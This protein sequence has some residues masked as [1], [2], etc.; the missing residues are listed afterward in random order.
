[1]TGVLRRLAP[2]LGAIL[3]F[4]GCGLPKAPTVPSDDPE[5]S[6][7]QRVPEPA[8]VQ[9]DPPQALRLMPGDRVT[10]QAFSVETTEYGAIQVDGAGRLHVPLSGDVPVGGLTLEEA[11]ARVQEAMRS[12][13]RVVRVALQLAEPGG[14]VATVVGAVADP[15][16]ITVVPGMRLADLMAEAGGP[17]VI[18]GEDDDIAIAADLQL[19]RLRRGDEVVPV[20]LERAMEGDPRHNVF[21]HPGDHLF[22]PALRG[23]SVIVIGSVGAPGV[24]PYR[25]NIRLTEA[26]AR[27]GGIDERGDRAD[28]HIVRGPLDNP[29]VFSA[30]LRSI[31][32]GNRPDIVLASGDVVYVT[33]EWTSHVGE[34]LERLGEFLSTPA[35]IAAIAILATQ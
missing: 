28:I 27:A 15:G 22:V 9:Q 5:F 16:R 7:P 34:V 17:R 14:Q 24:M 19:A 26:L 4:G 3:L 31:V 2:L 25:T 33:E 21:V 13:D 1:M 23:N 20:S 11:E 6:Q 10:I 32:D 18:E 35:S 12:L 29:R 8:G 30:S